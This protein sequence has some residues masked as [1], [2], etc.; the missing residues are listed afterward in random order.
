MSEE[1]QK[2]FWRE[3]KRR[4]PTKIREFGGSRSFTWTFLFSHWFQF[5]WIINIFFKLFNQGWGIGTQAWAA[6]RSKSRFA[7]GELSWQV[8]EQTQCRGFS[9]KRLCLCGQL[10][11][12]KGEYKVQQGIQAED[13]LIPPAKRSCLSKEEGQIWIDQLFK[14]K[15]TGAKAVQK[16][17]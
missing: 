3:W 4:F 11:A 2:T 7:R 13:D 12:R 10:V 17:R 9:W 6:V 14:K 16:A 15:L 8:P 5:L 1:V